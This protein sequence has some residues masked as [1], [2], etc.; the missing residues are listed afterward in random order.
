MKHRT[1]LRQHAVAL[2]AAAASGFNHG[3]TR[4]IK[5]R[6]VAPDLAP[7]TPWFYC[8]ANDDGYGRAIV[9]TKKYRSY[10]RKVNRRARNA[11]GGRAARA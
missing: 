9:G 5:P 8:T 10:K 7:E 4:I 1:S 3:V 2:L 11:N 6:E